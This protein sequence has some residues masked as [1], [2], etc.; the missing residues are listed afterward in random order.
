MSL[1]LLS[2]LIESIK[3]RGH[4]EQD[5]LAA[6]LQLFPQDRGTVTHLW[7]HVSFSSL[8]LHLVLV[9]RNTAFDPELPCFPSESAIYALYMRAFK[10]T[11]CQVPACDRS[12]CFEYHH[13]E[14]RRR[15]IVE[16]PSGH[17]SY[18]PEQC[19]NSALCIGENCSFAH[20]SWEIW[21]HPMRFRTQRCAA[22][23]GLWGL[24][25]YGLHCPYAH[26]LGEFRRP[27]RAVSSLSVKG[28]K[29][30]YAGISLRD[31][32]FAKVALA[33]RNLA[34]ELQCLQQQRV[35]LQVQLEGLCARL[36]RMQRQGQCAE[37]RERRRQRLGSCGHG[38]CERCVQDQWTCRVCAQEVK[39]VGTWA[40]V[41]N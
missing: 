22:G 11:K 23:E 12:L 41:L 5:C 4:T 39:L 20:N 7:P 6:L 34:E 38:V 37:C 40:S 30:R 16:L 24:C 25:Q 36:Q 28:R 29:Q 1:F 33:T 10:V 19:R 15:P 13:S 27:A 18:G 21:Y 3:R 32:S 26:H 8:L 35:L 31:I 2:E 9:H 17:W 14:D